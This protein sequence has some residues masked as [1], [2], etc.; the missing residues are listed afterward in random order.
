MRETP[1]PRHA[2]T[3]YLSWREVRVV[4]PAPLD[5]AEACGFWKRV[6]HPLRAVTSTEHAPVR[7]SPMAEAPAWVHFFAQPGLPRMQPR[8]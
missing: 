5:S 4:F 7:P 3:A 2:I 1:A 8:S 6:Q